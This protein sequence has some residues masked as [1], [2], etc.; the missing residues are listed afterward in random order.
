MLADPGDCEALLDD[1]Q[2][3]CRRVADTIALGSVYGGGASLTRYA[4]EIFGG[5]TP[6]AG[7]RLVFEPLDGAANLDVNAPAGTVFAVLHG[8][9]DEQVVAGY[10][11]YGPAAMLVMTFGESVAGF[12]YDRGTGNYALTHR[13]MRIPAESSDVAIDA[14]HER[15]WETPVRHYV[16]GCRDGAAGMRGRPF[17]LR[18]ADCM[19]AEIHRILVGGGVLLVPGDGLPLVA[20]AN[21]IAMIVEA[22]GGA[23]STGYGRIRDVVPGAPHDRVPAFIGARD[24]VERIARYHAEHERGESLAFDAP[25]FNE[26]SLFRNR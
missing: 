22:A 15:A 17:R 11:I 18:W 5:V 4:A 24:E 8:P 1:V 13:N 3:A 9:R 12:T 20:A 14:S 23:A 6:R 19:V 26:R 21:P 25:L 2:S 10:A 7:Y 16:D